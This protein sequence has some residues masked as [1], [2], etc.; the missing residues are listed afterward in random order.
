MVNV[1]GSAAPVAGSVRVACTVQ[2]LSSLDHS[3]VE[4]AWWYRM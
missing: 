3:A 4:I 1:T 2:R